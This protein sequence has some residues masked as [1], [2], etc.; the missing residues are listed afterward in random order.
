[1]GELGRVLMGQSKVGKPLLR[2]LRQMPQNCAGKS[3]NLG[4]GGKR[5]RNNVEGE[6]VLA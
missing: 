3:Q 6:A 4:A 1:M 5:K 2:K